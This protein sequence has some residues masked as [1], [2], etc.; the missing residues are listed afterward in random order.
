MTKAYIVN[1]NLTYDKKD[2]KSE[3]V[4]N[5]SAKLEYA[6]REMKSQ[7]A[8]YAF[9]TQKDR[10]NPIQKGDIVFLYHNGAGICA[11][12]R[13]KTGCQEAKWQLKPMKK[14][15]R[16]ELEEFEMVDPYTERNYCIP[17][18]ELPRII[19]RD[20]NVGVRNTCLRLC[21]K[22]GEGEKLEK[23][24]RKRVAKRKK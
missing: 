24:F 14:V 12:G 3:R 10:L 15:C 23:E 18:G 22:T 2:E 7:R 17:Y 21:D 19:G 20:G 9:G 1:T 11:V 4:K 5:P 16:V 13:A 8:A 6:Y